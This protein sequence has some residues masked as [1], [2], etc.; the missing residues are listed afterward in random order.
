MKSLQFN[1]TVA[2]ILLLISVTANAQTNNVKPSSISSSPS[3]MQ[4]TENGSVRDSDYLGMEKKIILWSIAGEIPS[5]FPKHIGGQTKDQY[6]IAIKG[7]AKNNLDL[8]KKEYH[9]KLL[10]NKKAT[11]RAADRANK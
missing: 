6:I 9:T 3:L 7:W 5:S 2:S 10:S 4:T 11:K 1:L 8:V